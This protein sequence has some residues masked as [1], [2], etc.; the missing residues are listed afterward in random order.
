MVKVLYVCPAELSSHQRFLVHAHVKGSG[1][2]HQSIHKGRQR[3]L[4]IR[5][6]H[7]SS[8]TLLGGCHLPRDP[9]VANGCNEIQ[10]ALRTLSESTHKVMP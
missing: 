5:Y 7:G 1:L 4:V 8:A 2:V 10:S 3:Q 6:V 9:I